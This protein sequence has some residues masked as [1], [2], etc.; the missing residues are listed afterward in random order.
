MVFRHLLHN[1]LR[2]EAK[3]TIR[4]K[5]AEAA[6][7]QLHAAA[8]ESASGQPGRQDSPCRLGIV[9]A[10]G[11][12]AGGLQDLLERV[13]S[14]RGHGF[15]VHRGTLKDR[16]LALILSGAGRRSAARATEALITGHKPQWVISAGFA[17]G[18]SPRLRRHDVLV[19]D[20]LVDAAGSQL[21]IDLQADP[22]LPA[23]APGIHVGRLLTADRV[24]RLPDEKRLLFRRYDAVAVDMETFAVAQVCRSRQVR[25]LAVRVINDTVD[26]ELPPDVERLLAQKTRAAQL[27]AAVGAIWKRPSSA[28]DMY[29]LKENAVLAS[30]RLAK[31]LAGFVERLTPRS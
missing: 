18:L 28:K 26:D 2:N 11:I 10:L 29:K 20:H 4:E 27:G 9:F 23:A 24:I 3:R 5:V 30:D 6:E 21:T 12:E 16:L 13:V 1:W 19:A 17:G 22:G 31:F 15:V 25:F 8:E 7:E 14:T